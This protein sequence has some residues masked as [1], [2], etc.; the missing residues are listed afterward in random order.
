MTQE[1]ETVDL[2]DYVRLLRRRWRLIALCALLG[3]A[4]ALATTLSQAKVYTASFQFFVSAQ[5]SPATASGSGDISNAYTGGLFTQQRVKSYADVLQS[6][7]LGELVAKDLGLKRSPA[8]LARQ[9]TATAPLDT[10]LINLS[11][12]DKS[13]LLAQRIAQSIGV[14]FPRVVETLEK[15]TNGGPAPVKVSVIQPAALPGTPTSPKPKLNLALGLL[16]GLAVGIGGAVLRETLDTSVK[17]PD[18][19]EEL[20][21]APMLGAISF[22]AEAP[23]NPLV[24]HTAPN[25]ARSEAFRQMRTNLQFVDIE[26]A[27]RSV[28]VTSSVPG[29]GKSTTTCNLSLSLAQAGVRVILVE[30]DLRRPRVAEYMGLEGA[31][32]LTSVLLGRVPLEDALQPWGDGI[33]QVL[34][35]GP[36]PPNPSELLGSAGMEQLL[37]RLEGLADIVLIDAPPLLPVTDA[38]VL[39]AMTSGVLMLVRS[40]RTNI[41]QVKRATTTANAVGATVLGV[42]LNAVPT[43]G[44]DAYGYGY[45]YSS[46]YTSQ[47]KTGKLGR[48][49]SAMGGGTAQSTSAWTR[50]RGRADSEAGAVHP[51]FAPHPDPAAQHDAADVLPHL[52]QDAPRTAAQAPASRGGL[53]R[54]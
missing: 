30:G 28:V 15:P 54:P 39:G 48:G 20:V 10:V 3:I 32:G 37:R 44:P 13:P 25:S 45:G 52:E 46:Y 35:S 34:P 12:K 11:V 40:N 7:R 22:D 43:S 8:S 29:E 31:V 27:L 16:V 5:G 38:A 9:V 53:R 26:H 36:L 4:A 2:R 17:S 24:V 50:L 23:K 1:S 41:E 21:G 49:E 47:S 18:Q 14:Q 6:P 42:I 51:G 33:L 19:A